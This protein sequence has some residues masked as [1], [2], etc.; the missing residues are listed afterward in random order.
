MITTFDIEGLLLIEPKRFGDE[1]GIF[2]EVFKAS[3]L[4]EAGFTK[5]FIQ[6]NLARSGPKGVIR[7]LHMQRAP[8][9]QDKLVRASKGAILDVAVDVRPGSKTFG[10][11]AAV[12]LTADNWRQLLVPAG[13]AHAYCTLVEDCEVQYKVTAPYAPDCEEG[14]LWSDPALG[15][16][17]PFKSDEVTVNARDAAWPTLAA[18]AASKG[19]DALGALRT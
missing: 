9:A 19:L 1:R 12:E 16:D 14:L 5:T 17:W 8:N 7:G 6:D 10:R 18:W 15:V 2:C 4:A 11:S 13:F 3:E